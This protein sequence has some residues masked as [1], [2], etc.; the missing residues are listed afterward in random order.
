MRKQRGNLSREKNQMKILELKRKNLVDEPKQLKR[1][2]KKKE[3]KREREREP[4]TW[5]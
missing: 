5:Q 4:K 2:N 1:N 3:K